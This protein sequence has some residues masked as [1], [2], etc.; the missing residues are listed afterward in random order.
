MFTTEQELIEMFGVDGKI[1]ET[2]PCIEGVD[3]E[4]GSILP[5]NI[6]DLLSYV[7]SDRN[8][9]NRYASAPRGNKNACKWYWYQTP[10]ETGTCLGKDYLVFLGFPPSIVA[11]NYPHYV[12]GTSYRNKALA[13]YEFKTLT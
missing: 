10:T 3:Y 8:V 9:G 4:N 7:Y 11:R 5:N 12:G 13:G 2:E 1:P 6:D